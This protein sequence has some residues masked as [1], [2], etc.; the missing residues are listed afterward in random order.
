D[1][2]AAATQFLADAVQTASPE[3]LLTMLYDRLLLDLDRAEADQRAGQRDAAST[4]L[5]H[6]QD[7]VTE[8]MATL[9]VAAW[10]GAAQ[11]MSLYTYVLNELIDAN[12]HGDPERVA[13]CREL[14]A[15]LAEAW[16]AAADEVSRPAVGVA[17]GAT[18][19]LGVG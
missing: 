14:L 17:A 11:L 6:A 4:H 1:M 7:I 16:R 15:P 5:L 13:A 8:L 2:N 18:G 10:D 19:V 12:T 3:R 9:D